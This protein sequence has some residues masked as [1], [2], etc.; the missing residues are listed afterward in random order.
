MSAVTLACDEAGAG[1]PLLILHGLFGSARN[2]QNHARRLAERYHVLAVDQRNHGRSSHAEPHD[3]TTLA[4]DILDL[5]AE[6]ALRDVVLL[7]HSMGGKVAM[8][9]ALTAPDR[10]SKL[11][12]VD[13]APTAYADAHTPIIDAML[14]LP[15][16]TLRRRQDADTQLAAAVPERDI[17]LFLLQNLVLDAAGFHWRLNLPVLR[18]AMPALIGALPVAPTAR[19]D[20]PVHF[21]RGARSDRVGAAGI[22]A[23]RSHFPQLTVHTVP[24]AGHWPHAENPAAF[25]A[26]LDSALAEP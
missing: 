21:I 14:A 22:A 26:C 13:I 15:L 24:D 12:I 2:W 20:G 4:Q 18:A 25:G 9:C 1:P 16:A 17:R 3:Y 8:T 7:G 19:F 10:F 23:S 11:V 5:C 6:H